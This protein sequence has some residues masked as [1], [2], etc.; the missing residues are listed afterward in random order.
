MSPGHRHTR[1]TS[2]PRGTAETPKTRSITFPNFALRSPRRHP[3]DGSG[4]THETRF[5]NTR[6]LMII[7]GIM[8]TVSTI[9][10]TLSSLRP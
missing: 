3:A 5:I 4:E 8:L 2:S 7:T 6:S 10:M 9:T 1:R